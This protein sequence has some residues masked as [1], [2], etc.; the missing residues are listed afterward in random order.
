MSAQDDDEDAF[1]ELV[2]PFVVCE[3]EGGPFADDAFVAGVQY[4]M[5]SIGLAGNSSIQVWRS[6]AVRAA[7]V[8]QYDLLA[9]NE[10]FVMTTEPVEGDDSWVT[11][12]FTRS[13]P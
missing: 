7:V 6:S 5:D 4:G 1:Y 9:M 10:G 8:P 11:V 3:S 13:R 2:M 12:T